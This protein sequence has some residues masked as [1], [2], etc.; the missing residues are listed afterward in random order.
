MVLVDTAVWSVA[1]R[2]QPA[3]LSV[4]QE[5]ARTA[6]ASLIEANH[7]Q[8]VG[9]VRQ[10]LLSCLRERLQYERLRDLLRAFRDVPLETEDYEQAGALSNACRLGGSLGIRAIF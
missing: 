1:F 9:A 5:K 6:L 10:E 8:L 3:S 7:A 4:D 2:R